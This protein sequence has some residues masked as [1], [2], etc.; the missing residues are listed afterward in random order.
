MGRGWRVGILFTALAGCSSP[1]HLG[2]RI[3]ARESVDSSSSLDAAVAM[4]PGCVIYVAKVTDVSGESGRVATTIPRDIDHSE[5][6][7]WLREEILAL[8]R[9]K[10]PLV[11]GGAS[12]PP[13]DQP[14]IDFQLERAHLQHQSSS[15]SAVLVGSAVIQGPD[16]NASSKHYRGRDTS[17]YVFG[18]SLEI[19]QS[20]DRALSNLTRSMVGDIAQLCRE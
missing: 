9:L 12:T 8:A 6:A 3:A 16:R 1:V 14:R 18:S 5:S 19:Q 4:K 7:S 20:F 10:L 11:D 15:I 17:M 13:A 2:H